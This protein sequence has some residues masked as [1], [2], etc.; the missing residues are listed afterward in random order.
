MLFTQQKKTNNIFFY[1][2]IL[3]THSY[4]FLNLEGR[5]QLILIIMQ[6]YILVL[7]QDIQE[8]T[9]DIVVGDHSNLDYFFFN[10]INFFR[11]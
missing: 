1:L 4:I 7:A 11:I 2:I 3:T 8:Y 9:A 5:Y 6:L 10:W